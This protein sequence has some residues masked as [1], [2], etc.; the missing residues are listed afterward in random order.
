LRREEMEEIASGW[1]EWDETEEVR[2]SVM[3]GEVACRT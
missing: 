3:H 1:R 2:F